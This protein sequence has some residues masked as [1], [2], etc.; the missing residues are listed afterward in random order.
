MIPDQSKMESAI[1]VTLNMVIGVI[2]SY[3]AWPLVA[4]LYDIPYVQS[5]AI[6][7]TLIFTALSFARN[8]IVRRWFNRQLK[9]TAGWTAR[10]IKRGTNNGYR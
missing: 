2:V 9:T 7:I 10:L 6:G 1:E 5:Q 3:S 8:Y 4:D